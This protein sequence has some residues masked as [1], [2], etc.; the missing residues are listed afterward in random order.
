MARSKAGSPRC[1]QKSRSVS[2]ISDAPTVMPTI[3]NDTRWQRQL[4]SNSSMNGNAMRG[5]QG[6][7]HS[8]RDWCHTRPCQQAFSRILA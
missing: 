6:Q 7:A 8:G 4:V 3:R 5:P 1:R 2:P